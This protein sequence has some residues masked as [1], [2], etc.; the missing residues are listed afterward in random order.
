MSVE[1]RLAILEREVAELKRATPQSKGNWIEKITGSFKGDP[2]FGEILKRRYDDIAARL[3]HYHR[4][5]DLVVK[6]IV[7]VDEPEQNTRI[8]EVLHQ[9]WSS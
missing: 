6:S 1:E 2:E 7:A 8:E 5:E 3:D 4:P 9:S